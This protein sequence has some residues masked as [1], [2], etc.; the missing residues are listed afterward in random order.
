MT[1]DTYGRNPGTAN[2]ADTQVLQ[3]AMRTTM[4]WETQRR[5]RDAYAAQRTEERGGDPHGDAGKRVKVG[6]E[7]PNR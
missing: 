7:T 6:G 4:T 5:A 2:A 3:N 1:S